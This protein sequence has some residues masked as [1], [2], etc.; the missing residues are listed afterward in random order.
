[1]CKAILA[2]RQATEPNN[3]FIYYA[4]LHIYI[5]VTLNKSHLL[6]ET[7]KVIIFFETV[8]SKWL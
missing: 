5:Q 2:K 8:P 1:M 6:I 7:R 4:A 3:G